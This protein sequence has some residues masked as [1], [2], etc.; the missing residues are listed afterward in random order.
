MSKYSQLALA[1]LLYSASTVSMKFAA[2][3]T[4]FKLPFFALYG[5]ALLLLMFYAIIWQKALVGID[6]SKAYASK[7]LT[8]VYGLLAGFIFF[9]EKIGIKEIAASI[10]VIVGIYLVM[11]DEN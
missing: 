9:N 6:L 11:S 8:I 7:G 5:I 3:Q 2:M 1:M 4:P 10:I